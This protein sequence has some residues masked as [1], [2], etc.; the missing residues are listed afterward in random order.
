ME[1]VRRVM[2]N[3]FCITRKD[4]INRIKTQ[5][6]MRIRLIS[7]VI[8]L[9]F[10]VFGASAIDY[11]G[12]AGTV[13]DKVTGAGL[14]EGH[15]RI[16]NFG[17]STLVKEGNAFQK[18]MTGSFDNYTVTIEP[19]LAVRGLDRSKK[20]ILELTHDKYEPMFVDIDPSTMKK[21]AEYIDLGDLRMSKA[22]ML[23]EFTVTATKVKFYNKGDTIVYN[24][25]AFVLAEGS[26]LDALIAQLP[27]AELKDNGQIFVNGRFVENLLLN[28]KDFFK[29]NNK[30]MLENL[31]AYTVKDIAVYDGQDEMD[32]IMG[33]EYG[34]KKL[35]MDVR[36][37]REYMRGFMLNAEAGYGTNNRYLGQLFGMVYTDMTRFSFFGNANNLSNTW[38]PSQYGSGYQMKEPESGEVKIY[39]GGLDYNTQVANTPLSFNG[40]A[41]A[42]YQVRDD[43]KS[44]YTT[45]F[46]PGG[47]TYGYTFSNGRLKNLTLKT[48]H[49]MKVQEDKWNLQV[50]PKFEYARNDNNTSVA[51]AAF[52]RE[53][54]DVDRDFIDGIFNN[55]TGG[56]LESL[57]NRNLN[58]RSNN[59]HSMM[60]N[61]WSNGK[62]KLPNETD[63]LTYL[64]SYTY[65]RKHFSDR[66]RYLLNFGTDQSA[67]QF[68]DRHYANH[69]DYN[70]RAKGSF[71][72]IWNVSR[73][74]YLDMYYT[75]QR[76]HS[77]S[78]SDLFRAENYNEA[79][80]GGLTAGLPSATEHYMTLDPDNSYD[81]RYREESHQFNLDLNWEIPNA[82]L[83]IWLQVPLRLRRQW[84][85]YTRGEVNANLHRD[86]FFLGDLKGSINLSRKWLGWLYI[87]L[88]RSVVSPD[89]VDMVDFTNRLDPLNIKKGNNALKDMATDAI[90]IY[91]DK[92]LSQEKQMKHGY[93]LEFT[94]T[95]NALAYGYTYDKTTGVKTGSMYNVS[96]NWNMR[97]FQEFGLQFGPRNR[98]EFSQRT[99]YNHVRSADLIGTDQGGLMKNIVNRN[100]ISED[101]MLGY[102]FGKNRI[103]ANFRGGWNRY[104]SGQEGFRPFNAWDLKY[105]VSGNFTLPANFAI[106]TTFNVFSRRGYSDPSLNKD[107]FVWNARVSYSLLK[108]QLLLMVDGY[109][110]LHNLSN[111]FYTVNAQARTET[112]ANTLP[113]YFMF[114]LQWKFHKLPKNKEKK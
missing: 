27:G 110:M 111:V 61:I 84:L 35:T 62:F 60:A 99:Q 23:K 98:F 93:G 97:A 40:N 101:V 9:M 72:Y 56:V 2:R 108:G 109:D 30:V 81:S 71:G 90:R 19:E 83:N 70:W 52:T 31:G 21:K 66:E 75:Y 58:D 48:S 46:L 78:V 77:R 16:L 64:A 38:N 11:F 10:G 1:G 47:D 67:T 54:D 59:G 105:G 94:F 106:Q 34:K 92:T 13:K 112:Y 113:R 63:A 89:M 91:L 87:G 8:A 69:P 3:R 39:S 5:K 102:T 28:G 37:K 24:A 7:A 32:R 80:Q 57:I 104:T 29:G 79:T 14:K 18:W 42:N 36:L 103:T 45:N 25:D 44:V 65:N 76:Y 86:K 22:K 6:T 68:A 100:A 74:V 4:W 49:T 88:D 15:Y 53:W 41:E 107:N 82:G 51:Q 73:G 20:Y 43:V 95:E 50:T 114:H 96:G 85:G 17:D 12:V 33:K 55:S 26:M